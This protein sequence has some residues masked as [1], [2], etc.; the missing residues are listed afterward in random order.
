MTRS[1]AMGLLKTII[2]GIGGVAIGESVTKIGLGGI[3]SLLAIP[4][5]TTG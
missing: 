2:M 3:K 4:T 1:G 5:P